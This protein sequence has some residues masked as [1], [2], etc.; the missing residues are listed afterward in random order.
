MPDE[1]R[2]GADGTAENPYLKAAADTARLWWQHIRIAISALTI[3]PAA[4]HLAGKPEAAGSALRA[5]PLIGLMIGVVVGGIYA[6]AVWIGG[7]GFVGAVVAIAALVVMTGTRIEIGVSAFADALYRESD[8]AK[9]IAFMA[10]PSLGVHGL[11]ALLFMVTLKIGLV[12]A[13]SAPHEAVAAL[14]AAL[15]G[16]RA[17]VP[18]VSYA[19][20]P[21]VRHK[22]TA[23]TARPSRDAMWIAA[24]LGALL[25]L[26]FLGPGS[27][28]A[29]LAFGCLIAALATW[30]VKHEIDG[31]NAEGL[32][33]I[34]SATEIAILA[35]GVIVR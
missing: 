14:I 33:V 11:L 20:S 9:R 31:Y 25:V 28:F 7:L 17:I 4:K 23:F 2:P 3:V 24:A 5:F 34:I 15:V 6:A 26:L 8:P 27:G 35:M 1:E 29:A 16:S 12:A 30:R 32:A 21:V 19:V 18:L 13:A 22:A 10:K